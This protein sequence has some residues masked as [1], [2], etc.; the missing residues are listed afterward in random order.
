MLRVDSLGKMA[1]KYSDDGGR[2]WSAERRYL[3]MRVTAID[4]A[5]STVTLRGPQGN[6]RTILVREPRRL[7]GVNVG[8]QIVITYTEALAVSVEPA[9]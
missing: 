2:S 3:P 4:R 6:T 9:K 7:E 5:N 8:D 1:F